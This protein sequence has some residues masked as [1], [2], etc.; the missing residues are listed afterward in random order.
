[1][2]YWCSSTL[3]ELA[4]FWNT[5]EVLLCGV[6]LRSIN[7]LPYIKP[8]PIFRATNLMFLSTQLLNTSQPL[9][10]ERNHDFFLIIAVLELTE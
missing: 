7:H 9:L 2:T 3:V 10:K 5:W 1:M 8:A 6:L 4:M